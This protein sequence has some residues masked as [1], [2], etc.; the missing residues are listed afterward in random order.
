MILKLSLEG[1]KRK[2]RDYFILFTGLIVSIAVFYMFLTLALN[3][4]FIT[5]NSVINHI[6]LVFIVGIVLLSVITFFYL[7]YT[8]AFLLSLRKKEFGMYELI[9]AKKKQIKQVFL[10]ET[11]LIAAAALGAGIFLGALLSWLVSSLLAAQLNVEFIAFKV[12][13]GPA[14]FW[15]MVYFLAVAYAVSFINNR[16]LAKASINDLL[17][18]EVKHDPLPSKPKNSALMIFSGIV[19]LGIGYV[20][21]FFMEILRFIGLFAAP[22]ATT[23]GTYLL[24]ASL[25]PIIVRKWKRNKKMNFR[26]LNSFTLAQLSFRLNELKWVLATIA[27]LIALSAGAIAGGFA[28]KNNA[29][30]SVDEERL[31]DA[32][33]YNPGDAEE[34]VL[35]TIALE[36]RLS[37]RF[38]M[39]EEFVYY[40]EDELAANP[41]LIVDWV[42]YET[43]RPGPFPDNLKIDEDG[44]QNLGDQWTMALETINP[45]F[46]TLGRHRIVSA[47]T[48]EQVEAEE[49]TIVLARS[50][51]F[52]RYIEQWQ[53]LDRLQLQDGARLYI[54]MD[55][56]YESLYSKYSTFESQYAFASGTFFMGFFLGLAFLTMMASIL[57]FKILS[58][59][60]SDIR[61]YDSLRKLG[62]RKKALEASI[63]KEIFIVFLF[64]ALLGLLHVFVGMRMFTFVII[65]PYYRLWISLLIFLAIYGSYYFFTVHLYR[66]LVLPKG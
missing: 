28:F 38:K 25:L 7:Y 36:E 10:L 50:D 4:E 45:A 35:E 34:E 61:R 59:A 19:L 2:Q 55:L 9:G 11:M 17:K 42:S 16:K 3:K 43:K 32:A 49:I 40:V 13:Y 51:K 15:T 65:D 53:E 57:M 31:Y 12:F 23:L 37:Y 27:M 52:S 63:S 33:L 41:P 5:G 6:Q 26:G 58:G 14:A 46:S 22:A 21:L 44:Y 39:D 8:N 47:E 62:V 1:L 56:E 64:P 29:V 24:F 20:A 54:P 60:N 18:A 48:F 30:L 66:K